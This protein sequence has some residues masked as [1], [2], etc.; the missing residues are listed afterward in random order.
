[1]AQIKIISGWT[2]PG[3]STVAFINLCNLFNERGHDCTLYGP[4]DWH[5]GQCKAGIL[6]ECP[7][8]EEG[9]NI[10]AHYINL[11]HR[12]ELSNKVVLGCHETNMYP[13]KDI[14]PFWDEIAYVSNKQMFWQGVSGTVIPNIISDLVPTKNPVLGVAGVIG[15]IDP[16]KRTHVSI[17]RALKDGYKDIRIFGMTTDQEYYDTEVLPLIEKHNL[18]KMGHV[19]NKQQMYDSLSVV[20][21]SSE[22]ETFNF[23][24]VE[25]EK[26]GTLYKGWKSAESGAELWTNT[27]ILKAWENLLNL[28]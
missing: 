16:H 12:P 28:S 11:P 23:I 10:I 7:L 9:E 8:N 19:D 15:S 5:L 6:E 13:I 24:E 26:T 4:H 20:Y 18:T 17:E 27:K 1:M 2:A 22:R 25:C 21:H 3:G 14:T